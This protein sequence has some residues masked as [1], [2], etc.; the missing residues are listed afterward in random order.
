MTIKYKEKDGYRLYL[1]EKGPVLGLSQD[2]K[3]NIIEKDGCLF[4]DF[5]GTGQLLPYED[6]RLDARTRAADLASRLSVEE[7]AGLM[8]Y[9]VHQLVPATNDFFFCG[10]YGGKEY[11]E[12]LGSD[13]S[14]ERISYKR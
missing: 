3:V 14:A 1:N 10:T 7:I 2:T 12:S 11:A 8:L 13:R 9:S 6:W 5:E 4:K